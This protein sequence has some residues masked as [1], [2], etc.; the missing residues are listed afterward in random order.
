MHHR[1]AGRDAEAV[2]YYRKIVELEAGGG[3]LSRQA[4]ASLLRL[5]LIYQSWGDYAVA[6]QYYERFLASQPDLEG[7]PD[8]WHE[9][10]A[11]ERGRTSR[12]KTGTAD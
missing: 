1:S 9:N 10:V 2:A 6:D 3:K 4:R 5:A 7:D 8:L 11:Y 12:Q